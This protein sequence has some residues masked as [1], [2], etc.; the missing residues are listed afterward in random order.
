MFAQDID[1]EDRDIYYDAETVDQALCVLDGMQYVVSYIKTKMSLPREWK[2]N[3]W[4]RAETVMLAAVNEFNK[5]NKSGVPK[6]VV[7]GGSYGASALGVFGI[8][9]NARSKASIPE[10][11]ADYLVKQVMD[12]SIEREAANLVSLANQKQF[13]LF[14]TLFKMRQ[15]AYTAKEVTSVLSLLEQIARTE[16]NFDM[17]RKIQELERLYPTASVFFGQ[18]P[19]EIAQKIASGKIS[20]ATV[21][22][23]YST[24]ATV[25]KNVNLVDKWLLKQKPQNIHQVI[26]QLHSKEVATEIDQTIALASKKLKFSTSY[27]PKLIQSGAVGVTI[28]G[29]LFGTYYLFFG[30]REESPSSLVE[31]N[32]LNFDQ[33]QFRDFLGDRPDIVMN[34]IKQDVY[35]GCDKTVKKTWQAAK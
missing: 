14:Q 20:D 23:A 5:E 11:Y 33:A 4:K 34:I 27:L 25:D 28:A 29:V 16:N 1:E 35:F 22:K 32:I 17:V 3:D 13:S 30:D 24:L 12:I 15:R 7:W 31:T 2:A 6:A 9:M 8:F 21:E 19:D 18:T 26:S 10:K